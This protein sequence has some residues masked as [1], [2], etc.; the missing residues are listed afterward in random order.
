[1]RH[2]NFFFLSSSHYAF[3]FI[4]SRSNIG[5]FRATLHTIRPTCRSASSGPLARPRGSRRHQA[6][7]SSRKQGVRIFY[8]APSTSPS[9]DQ[10]YLF[11]RTHLFCTDTNGNGKVSEVEAL[12]CF[13]C[14]RDNKIGTWE[15]VL[16][17]FSFMLAI[18][19]VATG[20]T[21]LAMHLSSCVEVDERGHCVHID[22]PS[23]QPQPPLPP[24]PLSP[25][26]PP[27]RPPPRRWSIP[28]RCCAGTPPRPI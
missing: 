13:D 22:P 3:H 10:R 6:K 17:V 11:C 14:N 24:P 5:I 18:A 25:P 2:Q 26:A 7:R 16:C 15:R 23:M 21:L 4:P 28:S 8:K 19:S 20:G 9:I 27:W 1:M 12:W